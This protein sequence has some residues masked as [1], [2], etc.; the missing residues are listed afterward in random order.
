LQPGQSL[1]HK[2]AVFHFT[3]NEQVLDNI[4]QKVLQ[5]SLAAMKNAF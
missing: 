1:T 2:H 3:G 4:S 5:I